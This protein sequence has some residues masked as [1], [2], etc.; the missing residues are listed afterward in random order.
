MYRGYHELIL[1]FF[2]FFDKVLTPPYSKPEILKVKF[3]NSS[4]SAY[5]KYQ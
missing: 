2:A 1:M 3:S 5:F 4:P